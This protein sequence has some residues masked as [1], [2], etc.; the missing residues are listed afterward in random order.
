MLSSPRVR[1][2]LLNAAKVFDVIVIK[3]YI[4]TENENI[5]LIIIMKKF[6]NL[7]IIH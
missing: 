6:V 4:R 2:L 5:Y 1:A 7:C 3:L